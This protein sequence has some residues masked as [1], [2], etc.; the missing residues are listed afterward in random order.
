MNAPALYRANGGAFGMEI[1]RAA[2][3]NAKGEARAST[4]ALRPSTAPDATKKR[5]KSENPPA[6][7]AANDNDR[8]K[9]GK[10]A[11][12]G[13]VRGPAREKT[14]APTPIGRGR[15]PTG[16]LHTEARVP[17]E[18]DLIKQRL[19]ALVNVQQKLG[20]LKRSSNKNFYEIGSLLHR[21]REERLFEVKG[22]SSLE[23]FVEREVSLG[24]Q[25]CRDA[26]RIF[27]TF[28]PNAASSLGFARLA[29]AI[30]VID[31]EP[32]GITD[33]SRMARSHIPPH[34]L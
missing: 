29:A 11:R 3:R 13:E 5:E 16:S 17:A 19:T 27:E 2:A 28:L 9:L 18:A 23:A 6:L 15:L 22:Y 4:K 12:E 31:D 8:D 32:T 14:A 33:V 20:D 1:K 7:H 25:F 26:V 30:K 24:Q 21:V 10:P 34:K